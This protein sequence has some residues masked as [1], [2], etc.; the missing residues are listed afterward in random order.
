MLYDNTKCMV[1]STG[2]DTD[3]SNIEVGLLHG[4]TP[5]LYVITL[6]Y[7]LRTSIDKNR[8]IYHKRIYSTVI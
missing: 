5:L 3:V 4:D 7:V 1:H 8:S 2:G 6:D